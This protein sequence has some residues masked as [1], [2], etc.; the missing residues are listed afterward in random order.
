MLVNW[1]ISRR[2][3]FCE[4]MRLADNNITC[5][6]LS[7]LWASLKSHYKF[8]ICSQYPLTRLSV[9]CGI[10]CRILRVWV[11]VMLYAYRPCSR[12]PYYYHS[13]I[14][15]STVP[16]TMYNR[17]YITLKWLILNVSPF[18]F[19]LRCLFMM[20]CNKLTREV[21]LSNVSMKQVLK[22]SILSL[23]LGKVRSFPRF[24]SIAAV[25]CPWTRVEDFI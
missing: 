3:G 23:R 9:T 4:R 17:V 25:T 12:T 15:L 7:R 18:R 11:S 8:Q 21:K 5:D 24:S 20:H 13:M 19:Y 1:T 22:V 16:V 14:C 2:E 10:V 6:L